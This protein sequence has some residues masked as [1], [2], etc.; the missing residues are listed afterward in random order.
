[1]P[2][3]CRAAIAGAMSLGLRI[4]SIRWSRGPPGSR[5]RGRS[6]PHPVRSPRSRP[7][8]SAHCLAG[9]S[10]PRPAGRAAAGGRVRSAGLA[11]RSRRWPASDSPSTRRCW[12][13]RRNRCK[14]RWPRAS[15]RASFSSRRSRR[16]WQPRQGERGPMRMQAGAA[17]ACG[18]NS[19]AG[20][21]PSV[22]APP[23]GSFATRSASR[24]A[25]LSCRPVAQSSSRRDRP[26]WTLSCVAG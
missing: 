19:G 16:R 26:H 24:D 10:S 9:R 3:W 15:A 21:G 20:R 1:M 11:R 2:T 25:A 5:R 14:R 4:A 6:R 18:G 13:R 12:P 8:V 17:S 23:T 7:A 22:A